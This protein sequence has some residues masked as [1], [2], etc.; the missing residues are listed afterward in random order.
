MLVTSRMWR[1]TRWMLAA[2]W[3]PLQ[4]EA[5]AK[6]QRLGRPMPLRTTFPRG[7]LRS[8]RAFSSRP[9]RRWPCLIRSA[10]A[11]EGAV[12][13]A[14]AVAGAEA[15]VEEVAPVVEVQ[16]GAVRVALVEVE[17]VAAGVKAAPAGARAEGVARAAAV[18]TQQL[19][20]LT[21]HLIINQGPSCRHFHLRPRPTSKFSLRWQKE[22]A[23]SRFS[24]PTTCWEGS[25]ASG[26]SRTSS[27][28][29]GTCPA[30][31]LKESAT[32]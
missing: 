30:T 16:E 7:R 8:V 9:T 22:Q 11:A 24:I 20:I 10:R 26:E 28:F 17:R 29:W 4:E 19:I 12:P 3:R 15:L 21:I 32:R 5:P 6:E 31:L 23:V 14:V 1:F 13:A 25:N 18:S 27:T 2:W